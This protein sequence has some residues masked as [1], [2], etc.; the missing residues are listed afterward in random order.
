[1]GEL[2]VTAKLSFYLRIFFM[3]KI[4]LEL[5]TD[6]SFY[7]DSAN[8]PMVMHLP[9]NPQKYLNP[10]S[11]IIYN[12]VYDDKSTATLGEKIPVLI[13]D[14]VQ[15]MR[16]DK[17]FIKTI[18]KNSCSGSS[19]CR[20]RFTMNTQKNSFSMNFKIN[21]DLVEKGFFPVYIAD[22]SNYNEALN[23]NLDLDEKK[24]HSGFFFE[25]SGL[26]QGSFPWDFWLRL[27]QSQTPKHH[28]PYPVSIK[29]LSK[30]IK[31]N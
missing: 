17:E 2:S 27:N 24:I 18:G 9:V 16:K 15:P 21:K 10:G 30:T 28:C 25:T 12:W 19:I 8:I 29:T 14:W 7:D 31:F 20:Y 6:V 23:W 13:K 26:E 22:L 4:K 5:S 3:F 11:G 1:M